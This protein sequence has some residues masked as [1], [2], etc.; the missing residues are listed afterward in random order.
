M[1]DP[2]ERKSILLE[3]AGKL[4]DLVDRVIARLESGEP[5]D[6]L[7]SEIDELREKVIE[8]LQG[9]EDVRME[10]VV[11]KVKQQAADARKKFQDVLGN[12]GSSVDE[13]SR[14]GQSILGDWFGKETTCR[15]GL[16]AIIMSADLTAEYFETMRRRNWSDQG[17]KESLDVLRQILL[18]RI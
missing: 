9:M 13:L 14:K 2:N 7:C 3:E 15:D 8:L 6:A 1:F 16:K 12:I 10:D 18:S 4:R 17:I 5:A 11:K